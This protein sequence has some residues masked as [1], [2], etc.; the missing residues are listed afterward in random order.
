MMSEDCTISLCVIEDV[1]RLDKF[2]AQELS[3]ISRSKLKALIE[4]GFVAINGVVTLD[5]N[6]HLKRGD[7]I[8]ANC[9]PSQ[10]VNEESS[11]KPSADSTVKFSILYEDSD[12]LVVS[13]PAG[14]V[15]HPGAGNYDHT[16]V[17]GLAHHCNLSNLSSGSAAFR[18][19]I[20]HR[21]DKDTSGIL[22]IAKNDRSHAVLADQFKKHSIRRKYICFCFG[23][24]RMIT[25]RIETNI[26]RDPKNR[27]KMAVSDAEKGKNAITNYKVVR[28]FSQ[29]A[30]KIECELFTGRTHQI[31][32]HMSHIGHS[33][34]GDS[35]Y[36]KK[37]YSIPK[38]I[39]KF[40]NEF[41]RQALHAYFLEFVHPTSGEK[42]H[43]E[44]EISD[45]LKE[46][47]VKMMSI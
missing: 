13:K 6:A 3:D 45:D 1:K 11:A 29:F 37:N 14:V 26:A 40:M 12:L 20:V 5:P 17:N 4:A 10:K 43:F 34:I 16:L 2:L 36:K 46:L 22:V 25:G 8:E 9:V 27:L 19:G 38:N 35:L 24:P 18:P 41:P 31:R 42:M 7:L 21:I 32:V 15:V 39:E 44:E 47:E 28:N 33:L 30:A 23:V